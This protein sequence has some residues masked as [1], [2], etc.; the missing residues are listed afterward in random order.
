LRL[1][2]AK[3]GDKD[4]KAEIDKVFASFDVNRAVIIFYKNREKLQLFN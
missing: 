3:I 2:T 1:A 4:S